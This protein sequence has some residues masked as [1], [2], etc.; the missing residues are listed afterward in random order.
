M[1]A[2]A[3]TLAGISTDQ[4]KAI[5]TIAQALQKN[6]DVI[7][8]PGSQN[9][10]NPR[11]LGQLILASLPRS[12]KKAMSRLEISSTL[13]K[14]GYRADNLIHLSFE[15]RKL[16]NA[17]VVLHTTEKPNVASARFWFNV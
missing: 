13:T 12:R 5:L 11:P 7:G 6:Y 9:V 16:V 10:R 3:L 14:L 4:I 2:P 8:A 1:N 15:L 17:G